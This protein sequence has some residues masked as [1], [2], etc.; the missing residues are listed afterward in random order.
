MM[1][2]DTCAVLW[3]AHQPERFSKE[4]LKLLND[5]A[6]VYVSAVSGFEIALKHKAGK[7]HLPVPPR[8]WLEGIVEHHGLSLIDLDLTT[9]IKAVELPPVH[10]DPC[11]RFIIATALLRRLPVVTADRRFQAYGVEVL[12]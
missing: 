6:V 3:L 1:L 12:I 7:L 11:D 8:E 4:A 5:A 10:Q 9:C 2:L